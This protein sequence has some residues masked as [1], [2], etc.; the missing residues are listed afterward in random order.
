MFFIFLKK[1]QGRA[2]GKTELRPQVRSAGTSWCVDGT[3]WPLG[4]PLCCLYR[5]SHCERCGE[6]NNLVALVC[7]FSFAFSSDV[8]P[9]DPL[10]WLR[11]G[12]PSS[13]GCHG[14]KVSPS[15]VKL[16]CVFLSRGLLMANILDHCYWQFKAARA[17]LPSLKV[18]VEH[19]KTFPTAALWLVSWTDTRII[20]FTH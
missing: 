19:E 16:K 9:A 10:Y 17:A 15:L 11:R 5:F 3:G 7:L 20:L 1:I 8:Y 13:V 18:E 14:Y 12:S 2:A 4:V 6:V